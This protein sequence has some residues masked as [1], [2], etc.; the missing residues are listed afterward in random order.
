MGHSLLRADPSQLR[1]AGQLS[2]KQSKVAIDLAK[3]SILHN[4]LHCID[5]RHNN[6]SATTQGEGHAVADCGRVG[7]NADVDT[8]VVGIEVLQQ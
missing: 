3:V 1:F 7:Q 2:P 6:F 5:S 8:G 4:K